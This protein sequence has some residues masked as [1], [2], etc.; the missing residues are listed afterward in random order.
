M[1]CGAGRRL[2]EELALRARNKGAKVLCCE[3]TTVPPNADSMVFHRHM[4]FRQVGQL[5]TADGRTEALL[6][7][8]C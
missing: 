2:Y 5:S 6:E 7:R 4:G 1:A 8:S 3:V